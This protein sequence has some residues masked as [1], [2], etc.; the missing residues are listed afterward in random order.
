MDEQNHGNKY[1]QWKSITESDFVTLFIKTWFT[2]IA[3]LRELNPNVKVFTEEGKPR[4]DK[5]FLNAYKESVMPIVQKRISVDDIAQE[6]F[7]MYPLSMRKVIDVFPQFFFHTFFRINDDFKYGKREVSYRPDGSIRDRYE[8]HIHVVKDNHLKLSLGISGNYRTTTYNETIKKDI[9]LRLAI[10]SIVDKHRTQ[11]FIIQEDQF[12]RDFYE[13]ILS[14]V[15]DALS[16]YLQKVLP[17]KLYCPSVNQRIQANCLRLSHDLNIRFHR[18]YRFPH[19]ASLMWKKNAYAIIYQRPF[20]RFG[21]VGDE[22]YL[23]EIEYYSRLLSTSGIDWFADFVYALRNALFHEIISPLDEEWQVIFKSAYLVLKQISDIC[24]DIINRITELRQDRDNV[25]FEYVFQHKNLLGDIDD[26]YEPHGMSLKKWKISNGNIVVSGDF[27][28]SKDQTGET[29]KY[30]YQATLND[31]FTIATVD[32]KD[33]VTI[34]C[35]GA[36]NS[37]VQEGVNNG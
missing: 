5:P 2:F 8:V 21:Q 34:S 7:R 29:K 3:V 24:I 35:I 12:I 20:N 28:L 14:E 17:T 16:H 27:I 31:D 30:K 10:D 18:N 22:A 25:I 4:G 33:C 6:M 1:E 26:S 9:D 19:E 36:G 15:S 37:N 23:K 13:S 11:N 32:Q